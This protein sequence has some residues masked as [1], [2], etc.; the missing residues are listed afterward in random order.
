MIG[1]HDTFTC[2]KP[3]NPLFKLFGRWW[4]CQ[5]KGIAEQYNAGIRFFDIRVCCKNHIWWACHGA[6]RL[7][8]SFC[9]LWDICNHM[10]MFYPDAIYRIV[11]EKGDKV[12]EEMFKAEAKGLCNIYDNLWRVDIKS[13]RNWMGAI[14]N[15]NQ[16]LYDRGYKFALCNTWDK[17]L[18]YE[19]H[20][21]ITKDNWYKVNLRKE[22]RRINSQLGFFNDSVKLKQM[23]ESKDVLYFLDYCTNEY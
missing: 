14:E 9:C 23:M 7:N 11:L 20:G 15:N 18:A 17:P 8:K 6:V 19:L 22:A 3:V 21:K 16:N 13:S 10:L 2:L 5:R 4:K 12:T 1:S